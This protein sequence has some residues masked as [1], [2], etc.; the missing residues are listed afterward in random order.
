MKHWISEFEVVDS[1]KH[2]DRY[3]DEYYIAI[4]F[5]GV[6]RGETFL[7]YTRC[8]PEIWE[9]ESW[10]IIAEARKQAEHF[11][12]SEEKAGYFDETDKETD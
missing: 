4:N 5:R 2:W 9:Q 10:I 8:S 1:S 6:Y 11:V 12:D 3:S 7:T